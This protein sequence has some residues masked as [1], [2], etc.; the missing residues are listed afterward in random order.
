MLNAKKIPCFLHSSNPPLYIP[1]NL[2]FFPPSLLSLVK[3]FTGKTFINKK[4][5]YMK[6]DEDSQEIELR[7]IYISLG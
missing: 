3:F 6:E 2:F 5:K 1:L 7:N 4:E